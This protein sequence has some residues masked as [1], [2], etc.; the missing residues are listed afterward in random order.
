MEMVTL[1]KRLEAELEEEELKMLR[2]IRGTKQVR[3]FGDKAREARWRWFGHVTGRRQRGDS[4]LVR[5]DTQEVGVREEKDVEDGEMEEDDSL[6]ETP[7]H[8]L[9]F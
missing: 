3:S 6:V 2:F 8:Y 5:E 9:Y 4:W 7:L 1:R